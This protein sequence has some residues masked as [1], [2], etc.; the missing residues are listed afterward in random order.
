MKL[1]QIFSLVSLIA[2]LVLSFWIIFYP[3]IFT[4]GKS[5]NGEVIIVWKTAPPRPQWIIEVRELEKVRRINYPFL[6]DEVTIHQ[7]DSLRKEKDSE[8]FLL[9]K[10]NTQHWALLEEKGILQD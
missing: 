9:K 10:Q 3:A 5:L 1:R 7:G 2:F 4:K 8:E 6:N